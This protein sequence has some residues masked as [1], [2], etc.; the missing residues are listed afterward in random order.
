MNVSETNET[1]VPLFG[2]DNLPVDAD[3]TLGG[4]AWCYM[5]KTESTKAL[6]VEGPFKVLTI[7]GGDPVECTDGWLAV[8]NQGH[9]YPID[10]SVMRSGFEPVQLAEEHAAPIPDGWQGEQPAEGTRRKLILDTIVASGALAG[11][12]P[13]KLADEIEQALLAVEPAQSAPVD[14]PLPGKDPEATPETSP[15]PMA[16]GEQPES[17]E[18][19]A[20]EPPK[21]SVGRIVHFLDPVV[22]G[23][24]KLCAAIVTEVIPAEGV[25]APELVGLCV[26]PPSAAPY[27][28]NYV[29]EH[30]GSG[31][32]PDCTWR[33]PERV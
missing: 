24:S 9:P 11:D 28:I 32:Q 31:P 15:P 26:F 19:E 23:Q 30:R 22:G 18:P 12:E 6:R 21:P 7:H 33:F 10:D 29:H 4:H 20:D 8:D 2:K 13:L 3:P 1:N 25:G 27:A 17:R 5:R 16:G 14:E